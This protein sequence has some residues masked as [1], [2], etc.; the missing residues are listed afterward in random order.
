MKDKELRNTVAKLQGYYSSTCDEVSDYRHRV[1]AL[2]IKTEVS[3]H[4]LSLQETEIT[5]L[6]NQLSAQYKI[7][8]ALLNFLELETVDEG[9]KI[10]EKVKTI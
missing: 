9:V 6:K 3:S 1:G 8:N 2:E 5:Y 4:K 10:V 7:V